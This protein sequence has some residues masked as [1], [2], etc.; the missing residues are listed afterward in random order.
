MRYRIETQTYQTYIPGFPLTDFSLVIGEPFTLIL[1]PGAPA[2]WPVY[3]LG[4][5]Q[6]GG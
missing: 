3:P 4:S 6:Q 1:S 5:A 2:I